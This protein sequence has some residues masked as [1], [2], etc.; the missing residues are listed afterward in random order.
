MKPAA[1]KLV[2]G[3]LPLLAATLMLAA[4]LGLASTAEPL[5][6]AAGAIPPKWMVTI[7]SYHDGGLWLVNGQ[8]QEVVGP[9]LAGELG[10]PSGVSNV[11]VT[12]DGKQA[13]V[14]NAAEK[15]IYFVDLTDPTQPELA[16]SH[17]YSM[18][19]PSAVADIAITPDSRYALV[20]DNYGGDL[21]MTIDL[22]TYRP[23]FTPIC[24]VLDSALFDHDGGGRSRWHGRLCRLFGRGD[25][26]NGDR[27][28]R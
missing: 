13:I 12:P 27:R 1:G 10:I 11:E 20:I 14:S 19:F 17:P 24:A 21:L 7:D 25:R 28:I 18:P 16:P 4:L 9:L 5:Q 26:R 22:L 8:T 23:V 6:A 2:I 15:S 3:L